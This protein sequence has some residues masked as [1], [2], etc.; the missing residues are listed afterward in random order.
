M[1]IFSVIYR[2]IGDAR[3]RG[4]DFVVLKSQDPVTIGRFLLSSMPAIAE[5]RIEDPD[6]N[7]IKRSDDDDEGND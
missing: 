7:V 3:D 6:G 1:L 4:F 2:H 5:W